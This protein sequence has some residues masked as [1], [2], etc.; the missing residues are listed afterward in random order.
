MKSTR[1]AALAVISSLV[2]GLV[3]TAAGATFDDVPAEGR[4]AEH[5][6]RVEQAGIA[7]G[8]PDGTFRPTNPLSRQQ[9]AA[10]IDRSVSRSALDFSDLTSEHAPVDPADPT[11]QVAEIEMSSPAV[12]DGGG[13]VTLDGYV[14]AA[15]ADQHGTG[16]PCAF[17][18]TVLNSQD[19]VVAV[20][21]LT[22]PGTESD[23]ERTGI[24]PAGV[25]PVQG[26]VWLPAGA[27]ET[28]RLVLELKDSDVGD[29]LVAGV[30]SGSYAPMADG[31]PAQITELGSG[32]AVVSLLPQG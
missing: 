6:A 12:S 7:N 27:T 11:R 24:G 26:I 22:A 1:I 4:F 25:A 8:Y 10:W 9:A 17:D 31:D 32:D 28:Y 15:T 23:D 2:G 5:I 29:V 3:A 13:W 19:D 14:A 16:C 18:L 20:G 21:I 30:L